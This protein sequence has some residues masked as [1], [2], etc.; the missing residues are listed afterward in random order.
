MLVAVVFSAFID[1]KISFIVDPIVLSKVFIEFCTE[2]LKFVRFE[3]NSVSKSSIS[4]FKP[5]IL[6]S[7]AVKS[8]AGI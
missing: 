1:A 6:V 7:I 5:S 3:P 2:L 8:T 4:E